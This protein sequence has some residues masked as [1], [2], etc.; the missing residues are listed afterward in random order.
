MKDTTKHWTPGPY[1][2]GCYGFQYFT[3]R[4][5]RNLELYHRS[6][7]P[8]R[9]YAPYQKRFTNYIELLKSLNK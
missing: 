4:Y 8:P 5:Y 1:P 7:V 6:G 3:A 9:Q 2:F